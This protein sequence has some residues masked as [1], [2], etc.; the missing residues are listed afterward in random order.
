MIFNTYLDGI[1]EGIEFLM[2]FGSI[3]GL[4]GLIV[5]FLG[6]LIVPKFKRDKLYFVIGISFVLLMLCGFQTGLR[7]FRI[8]L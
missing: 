5:G 2:A 4:L 1:S 8:N 3:V 7:Y 6:M